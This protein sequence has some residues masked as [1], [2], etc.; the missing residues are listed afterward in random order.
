MHSLYIR[1]YFRIIPSGSAIVF[2]SNGPCVHLGSRA[3]LVIYETLLH[4][5]EHGLMSQFISFSYRYYILVNT[6]IPTRRQLAAICLLYHPTYNIVNCT[7][8]GHYPYTDTTTFV[9]ILYLTIP[10]IPLY[11]LIIVLRNKT[12]HILN[13]TSIKLRKTNRRFHIQLMK[14]LTLQSYTPLFL[15]AMMLMYFIGQ[16]Q[17]LN[18]PVLE[19]LTQTVIAFLPLCNP[20]ISLTYITPYRTAFLKWFRPVTR[21]PSFTKSILDVEPIL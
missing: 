5:L 2:A 21:T 18:H 11:V 14:V 1:V 16:F 9:T 19:Y 20:I 8:S 7:I 15:I 4:A 17:I 12:Y 10:N 3:C 13:N 6:R